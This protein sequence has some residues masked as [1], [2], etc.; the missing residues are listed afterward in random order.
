VA[1]GSS[2]WSPSS[3]GAYPQALVA[4]VTPRQEGVGEIQARH[5]LRLARPGSFVVLITGE[6][7]SPA[8]VARR[9][10]FLERYWRAGDRP[11]TAVLE[12]ASHPALDAPAGG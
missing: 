1:A 6:A 9:R 2:S 7:L 11:G 3:R 5:A 4:A 10:G 12:A 8:A